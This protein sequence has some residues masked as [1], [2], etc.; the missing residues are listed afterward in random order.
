MEARGAGDRGAGEPRGRVHDCR[1]GAHDRHVR[2]PGERQRPDGAVRPDGHRAPRARLLDR[3]AA[4][5]RRAGASA[6]A[7][8]PASRRLS[9]QCLQLQSRRTLQT[10][11]SSGRI[12]RSSSGLAACLGMTDEAGGPRAEI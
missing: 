12:E 10:T 4:R 6:R 9:H 11:M 2:Q 8:P 7:A 5:R 1:V 3:A